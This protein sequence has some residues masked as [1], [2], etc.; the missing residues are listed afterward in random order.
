MAT[1]EVA[2]HLLMVDC[3]EEVN[4]YGVKVPGNITSLLSCRE[5]AKTYLLVLSIFMLILYSQQV[6]VLWHGLFNL[7][8]CLLS[9][10]DECSHEPCHTGNRD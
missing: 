5:V 4:V 8:S 3:I 7:N 1:T 9:I 10:I 2:D 6:S